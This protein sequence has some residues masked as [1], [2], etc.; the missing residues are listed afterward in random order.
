MTDVIFKLKFAAKQFQRD[1]ARAEKDEK[2]ERLK[3]KKAIEKSDAEVAKIHAQNAIRKKSEALNFLR[4]SSRIDAVATRVSTASK[5]SQISKTMGG[6]VKGMDK[7]L[8]SMDAAKISKVMDDFEKNME[9][10]DVATGFMDS[11]MASQSAMSCPEDQVQDLLEAVADEHKIKLSVSM[12]GPSSQKL[13]VPE[14]MDDLDA[15][16]AKLK[17]GRM[18]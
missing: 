5:M 16:L 9:S 8:D 10:L 17:E 11:A 4:L 1:A 13:E 18:G 6:I 7:V 14:D 3:V 2:A 15:R 12:G